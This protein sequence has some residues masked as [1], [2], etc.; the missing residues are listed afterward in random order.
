MKNISDIQTLLALSGKPGNIPVDLMAFFLYLKRIKRIEKEGDDFKAFAMSS[1][2]IEW[3]SEIIEQMIAYCD[4]DLRFQIAISKYNGSEQLNHWSFLEFNFK[5]TPIMPTLDILICDPLGFKQSLVLTNLLSS[6]MRF[7][8]LSKLCTLMIYIP[9]DILQIAGRACAYFVSDSISMLSNQNKY[10]PIYDYMSTH[11]QDNQRSEAIQTFRSFREAIAR[12]AEENLDDI[13]NF[14][15]V[16]SSLP[17]RLLRTKH[18]VT[19][20]EDEI[21]DSEE[22]RGEIVNSKGEAAWSSI[23]KNLFFVQDRTGEG[24]HRN[25]RVNKKMEKLGGVVSAISSSLG[26]KEDI[27]LFQEAIQRHQLLGLEEL[28][29]QVIKKKSYIN[30]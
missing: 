13:Y 5:R 20:L 3:L 26:S 10:S 21:R 15:L 9:T 6:R 16:V 28:I 30:S 27:R 22:H 12:F 18:S 14:D 24:Q 17:T 25:M 8:I 1:D 2:E 23:S 7:G 19:A 29:S 4:T 11:Q